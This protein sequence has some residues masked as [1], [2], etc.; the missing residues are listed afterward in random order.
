MVD[1]SFANNTQGVGCDALLRP[2]Q[3]DCYI[4]APIL[5]F[6]ARNS[7]CRRRGSSAQ[8]KHSQY[9]MF[10][11]NIGLSLIVMYLGMFT[12]IDGWGDFRNNL[13]MFYLALTMLAPMALV[14]LATMGGMYGNRRLNVAL[15]VGFSVLFL[16]AFVAT[17]T[18]ALIDDRQFIASMI[19]HH[20]GAILMCRK[21]QLVDR[22]LIDLCR[23]ITAGQRREIELMNT[24]QARLD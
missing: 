18:Q 20:S 4:T 23:E 8:M 16:A 22:E 24:I 14:M 5:I 15:Y 2:K 21:A 17:R 19:P 7:G 3:G 11:L 13:N 9:S 1:V 6:P 10:T 12:M